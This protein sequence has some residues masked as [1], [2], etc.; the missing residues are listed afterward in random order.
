LVVVVV[1]IGVVVVVSGVV[2]EVIG[3]SV[4]V[5]ESAA[6]VGDAGVVKVVSTVSAPEQAATSSTAREVR[7]LCTRPLNH[8]LEESR[9]LCGVSWSATESGKG[10]DARALDGGQSDAMNDARAGNESRPR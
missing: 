1:E 3:V 6:V 8:S 5:G 7:I 2:D 9:C 10:T 4:V